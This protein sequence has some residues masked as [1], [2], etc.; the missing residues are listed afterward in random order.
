MNILYF[1]KICEDDLF[2]KKEKN[3][4]PFFIAQYMYEKILLF[5]FQKY[6]K[7]NID[8]VSIYQIEY[9]PKNIL[10]F[11]RRKKF[12][13]EFYTLGF[14]NFPFIRELSFFLSACIKILSWFIKNR[15]I[16]NKYIYSS[17]HFPPVSMA[18]IMM[19]K[20]LGIKKIIT[21]TDLSLFTYSDKKVKIMKLYKKIIIRPYIYIVNKLQRKYDL[22]LLFS[23]EM[24]HIVNPKNKPY[25]V[26]EGIFNSQ[27]LNLDTV[28]TKENA[29]AYAGSLNLE[30]GVDKIL[31]AFCLIKDP[32]LELWLI[33]SGDMNDEII[34][35]SIIDSRIKY[36][37][38]MPR[39]KMFDKLKDAKLLVNFRNP[40]DS[41][42]KYSFPSKMLDYMAT[43][44]PVLTT[45]L[46]GIPQEYY[47][48]CYTTVDANLD[49]LKNEILNIS[50]KDQT[51]LDLFGKKAS[52]FILENKTPTSQ[53][54]KIYDILNSI[55]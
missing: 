28:R 33:G 20:I 7:L 48:Y 19:G 25:L 45:K 8:V 42:T 9:F 36:L 50:R 22:Y 37:G 30:F 23:K 21:F 3:N 46:S 11:K 31:D 24:N 14:I 47:K 54:K 1:G 6:N 27:Q 35:R 49:S 4:L 40:S 39:N 10:F 13:N 51:E 17:C 16:K 26:I 44:T 5:E 12:K 52:K 32:S 43:G 38:F 53:V 15:H 18:V 2:K 34:K 41:Y 55:H 29:I